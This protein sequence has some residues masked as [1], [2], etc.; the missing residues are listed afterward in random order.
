[1]SRT[2]T[3]KVGNKEVVFKEL[4][5]EESL[6]VDGLIPANDEGMPSPIAISKIYALAAV[7]SIDGVVMRPAAGGVE[8]KQGLSMF[9]AS[10]AF[11]LA[12]AYNEAFPTATGDEQKNGSSDPA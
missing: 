2:A 12:K 11:Q 1:M 5:F 6:A 4:T 8:W 10:E 3:V 7:Q 9:S